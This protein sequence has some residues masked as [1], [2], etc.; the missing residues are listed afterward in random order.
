M[1]TRNYCWLF[2]SLLL[3]LVA[4]QSKPEF[5]NHPRPNLS[6]NFAPFEDVGCPADQYGM[7]RCTDDSPL[8]ALGC[9]EIQEPYGTLG[10]LNPSYPLAVCLMRFVNGQIDA[11]IGN[12]LYFFYQ[13]GLSSTYIRYVIFRD[14]EYQL[15]KSEA[16]FREV[17]APIETAE[18]ALSYVL[19]IKNLAAYYDL[20]YDRD[21]EYE[22]SRIEDTHVISQPDGYQLHLYDYQFFGCGPHWTSEVEVHV[23]PEGSI[24][25]LGRKQIFR[26]PQED[27]MCVD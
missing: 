6:V 9:D 11:D 24:Q 25:E 10:G 22:V 26:N 8:A 12:G 5:I 23:T 7:R 4:C 27:G 17:Y 1:K 19:A 18:E 13:G 14:D 20:E 2:P 21:L 3:L 16:E 15:L